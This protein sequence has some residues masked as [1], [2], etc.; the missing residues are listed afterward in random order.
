MDENVIYN[1]TPAPAG[2]DQPSPLTAEKVYL[3][4]GLRVYHGARRMV[5]NEADAE[6]VAQD[7]FAQVVRKLPTFRGEAAL[8]TWLHRVTVNAALAHRRKRA[9]RDQTQVA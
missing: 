4:F 7:V 3:E 8:P 5:N 6:D 2:A 9:L 1:P